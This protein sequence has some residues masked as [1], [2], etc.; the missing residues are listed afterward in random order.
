MDELLMMKII[1]LF[2][3][4]FGGLIF[5]I[6]P[7][8]SR[9]FHKGLKWA[10]L[11]S[12]F[13]G[14]IFLS[15]AIADLLPEATKKSEEAIGSRFP[16][17]S[18]LVLTGYSLIL[19]IE[20]LAFSSE[21]HHRHHHHS[22]VHMKKETT[23]SMAIPQKKLE[24]NSISITLEDIKDNL[25]DD[26]PESPDI[27]ESSNSISG[28]ILA[29]ALSI[30]NLLEGIAVGLQSDEAGFINIVT[31]V[32]FHHFFAAFALGINIKD[33]DKKESLPLLS[34]FVLSEPIGV[35]IG[36]GMS[37]ADVPILSAIFLSLCTGTFLY[38]SCSEIIV[39][40][41]SHSVYKYQK[42]FS[43]LLGVVLFVS[44]I[45]IFHE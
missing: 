34:I 38:I 14:G 18:V 42:Y 12:C 15:V 1:F 24:I 33:L 39:E 17:A 30:H 23:I 8:Y 29:I 7:I 32:M 43:Y 5:G 35:A 13:S 22:T 44:L 41:F 21:H 37:S 27:V 3:I 20:K 26:E 31:A 45:T 11:G 19:F 28:I 25:I 16:L 2:I 9:F 6:L 10:Y 4:C 40:E 36:I